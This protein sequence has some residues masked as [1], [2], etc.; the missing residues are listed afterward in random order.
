MGRIVEAGE[1]IEGA[2]EAFNES[3]EDDRQA[4]RAAGQDAGVADLALMSWTLWLLG[5]P[6]TAIARIDAALQRAEA[7]GH[8]HSRA[9]A[10]YYASVLYAL[11]GRP[12]IART[13]AENC[14]NLSETHGFRQ[15]HGLSRAIRGICAT[16]LD[17]SSAPLDDVSAALAEYRNAGY[18]L[19]ITA[20]YV[21]LCPVLLL[22]DHVD[23]AL[24]ILDRGL[25]AVHGNSERIFECE[26]YRLKA[27]AL[28]RTSA[29]D[30]RA[31]SDAM[32]ELAL[33][34]AQ[35]QNAKSIELR[36]A[37]DLARSWLEQGRQEHAR[38]LLT[39]I[40]SWFK[41]GKDMRDVREAR[42]LLDRIR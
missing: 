31:Q 29:A 15:W 32:L 36:I 1:T 9:Y 11:C 10:G 7:I 24:E 27:A 8:A 34:K 38:G 5:H 20:L 14:L 12:D 23:G 37:H 13:H 18:E 2:Y 35:E 25:A 41:E 19:G 22:H 39:P 28:R 30:A 3:S 33:R 21:L 16:M 40:C 17:K 4:A 42:A 6:E 26:L